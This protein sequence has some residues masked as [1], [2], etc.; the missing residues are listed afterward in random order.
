MVLRLIADAGR[1]GCPRRGWDVDMEQCLI[2]PWLHGLQDLPDGG[3][4]V[5]C[6]AAHAGRHHDD[7]PYPGPAFLRR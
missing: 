6:E 4:V 7:A 1:V 5:L 2:C 3:A